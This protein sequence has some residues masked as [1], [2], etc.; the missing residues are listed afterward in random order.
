MNKTKIEWCDSTWNPVT[1]CCHNC[2]YCYARRIAC[3]FGKTDSSIIDGVDVK[4]VYNNGAM[5]LELNKY[6]GNPYP[7]LFTP[8]FHK[9]KLDEMKNKKGQNVFVCSMADLFGEWVPDEWIEAVFDAC[10]KAPQ[11]NYMFLTKNPKRYGDLIVKDLLPKKDNMWFGTSI[12]TG[13]DIF[14]AVRSAGFHTF[15]SIEPLLERFPTKAQAK[16]KGLSWGLSRVEWAIIGAETGNRADKV[17]PKR[18]WIESLVIDLK[19]YNIPVF[20]KDS[21]LPIMGEENMLREFPEGLR[22]DKDND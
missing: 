16:E 22:K 21:L 15:V 6:V 14:I 17:V 7:W 19:S 1:G 9:Y 20:M 3:R 10:R 2:E 4:P 12:T 18:E 11:H 13:D 8:T 5:L